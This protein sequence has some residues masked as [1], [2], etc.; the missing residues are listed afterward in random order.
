VTVESH[1][2]NGENKTVCRQTKIKE[3]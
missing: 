1:D 2:N 3:T